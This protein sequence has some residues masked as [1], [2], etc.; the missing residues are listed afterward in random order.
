M[1]TSVDF[2]SQM[3]QGGPFPQTRESHT[4]IW[5][6]LAITLKKYYYYYYYYYKIKNI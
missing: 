1:Y 6:G 3:A 2:K 4:P 5:C